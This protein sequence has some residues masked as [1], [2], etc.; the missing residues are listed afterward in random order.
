MAITR[1]LRIV[2]A[3]DEV[4]PRDYLET[5]LPRLGHELVGL[6]ENGHQLVELCESQRPGLVITDVT[7]PGGVDWKPS[8]GWP[9]R[10]TLSFPRISAM[11]LSRIRCSSNTCS[12]PSAWRNFPTQFAAQ[13]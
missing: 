13:R 5:L 4:D 1:S 10:R 8:G 12:N 11:I 7:M 9:L 3:D 2:V 6:A